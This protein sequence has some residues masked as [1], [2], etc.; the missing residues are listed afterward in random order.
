[1]LRITKSDGW[2]KK[3]RLIRIDVYLYIKNMVRSKTARENRM[4]RIS[5][6]L[7]VIVTAI[8]IER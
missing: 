5:F 6:M 4:L 8:D 3:A 2:S 1:M 7:G